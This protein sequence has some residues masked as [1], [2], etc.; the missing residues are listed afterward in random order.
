MGS[1]WQRWRSRLV[2]RGRPSHVEDQILSLILTSNFTQLSSIRLFF[3][4]SSCTWPKNHANAIYIERTYVRVCLPSKCRAHNN[5]FRLFQLLHTVNA[6]YTGQVPSM[7]KNEGLWL[8]AHGRLPGTLR[9]YINLL[10]GLLWWIRSHMHRKCHFTVCSFYIPYTIQYYD[11]VFIQIEAIPG[12]SSSPTVVAAHGA[13]GKELEPPSISTH[14]HAC[15]NSNK[16]VWSWSQVADTY[17]LGQWLNIYG[18]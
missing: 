18:K 8:S 16:W 13:Q 15:V 5:Q 12:V 4:C 1:R 11:S 6:Q 9:Y 2:W 7:V 10:R 14:M 17:S 3:P